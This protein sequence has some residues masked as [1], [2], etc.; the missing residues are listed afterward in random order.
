MIWIGTSGWVYRDWVGRFYP[1]ELPGRDWLAFFAREFP[2]VE[3]NRSYYRLPTCEQFRAWAGQIPP[4][5]EGTCFRFAVK[6]SRYITHLKKLRDVDEAVDRLYVAAGGLGDR[7]G[8]VLYQLPPRWRADAPRLERFVAVL[9]PGRP[10]AFEFRDPTWSG[11][12]ILRVLG[13]A[14]CALVVAVG[15]S[16]PSPRAAPAVGPFRYV[17]FHHGAHGIGFSDAEL[18]PWVERLAADG[19]T[20]QEV[21]VYFNNVPGGHAIADARR[22]REMLVRAGAPV[23]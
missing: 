21:Y 4:D 2:T 20:G 9:P 13:E 6:A 11:A 12:E 14:G 17:R 16:H 23:G 8:P 15:G 22:L 3:I 18:A 7:L 1:R 10:A 19:A 5:R